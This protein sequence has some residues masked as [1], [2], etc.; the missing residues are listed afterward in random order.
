ML[1][2]LLIVQTNLM[3]VLSYQNTA[4]G[5][6]LILYRECALTFANLNSL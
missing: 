4:K 1:F 6:N 5:D 3:C 2:E